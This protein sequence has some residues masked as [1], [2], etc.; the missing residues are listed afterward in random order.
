MKATETFVRAFAAVVAGVVMSGC[1]TAVAVGEP[2]YDTLIAHR[3]ESKD[4]PENTMPAY[5]M[6]VD[7]GFGF[8][9]DV[10]VSSDKRVFSFHDRNLKRTTGV[11]KK[12]TEASWEELVSKIDAGSWKGD[13]WK[14]VRPALLEEIL[15]LARDGR[16]IYVEI[17]DTD[18]AAI[19]YIRQV[20]EKQSKAT[21]KNTLFICFFPQ[22]CR[23]LKRQMPEYK[24]YFLTGP[25]DDRVHPA[26]PKTPGEII[27]EVRAAD[28]DGVD[29]RFV[30]EI[31]TAD[32]VRKVREAGLEFHVWTVD[33]LDETLKAFAS[34]AQTVTT[35]C[36]KKQLDEYNAR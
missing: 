16:R 7:R 18:P 10:Y 32:F 33:A 29:I 36:A 2:A 9:C 31:V 14:G 21:P 30:P 1:T 3:G 20:F 26:R 27:N 25:V 15:T 5:R 8:E 35:N 23:E 6:A 22:M 17:K 4:A 24:V 28:A 11:D 34:G 12:C 19:K 13:K